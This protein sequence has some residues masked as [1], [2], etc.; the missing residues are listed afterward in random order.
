MH[1]L[2]KYFKN[3]SI[4][5]THRLKLKLI[6]SGLKKHKCECCENTEWR[7]L[8][9]PIELHHIDGT[10]DNRLDNL[11]LLCPNCHAQT[12]NYKSKNKKLPRYNF[13]EE[14][15]ISTIEKSFSVTEVLKN[16]NVYRS[17]KVRRDVSELIKN[18]KAKLL[19]KTEYKRPQKPKK[20]I[21]KKTIKLC[22]CERELKGKSERC[23]ECYKA[24]MRRVTRPSKES[25]E[26][27]IWQ[28]PTTKIAI[29]YGV[30]DKAIEKWCKQYKIAKPPRG[31]WAKQQSKNK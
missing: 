27:L 24:E 11:Q 20:E 5:P 30:T 2:D 15:L 28:Q 16:L 17:S 7:G 9:T 14:I 23:I 26:L 22:G 29:Q 19:K 18:G 21:K 8:P 1:E 4:I 10:K 31:Y 25:L 6:E 12:H 13:N 3:E